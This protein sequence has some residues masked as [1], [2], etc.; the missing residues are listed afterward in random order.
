M[1]VEKLLTADT[2]A[3]LKAVACV[4]N[5]G[6]NDFAVA[7]AGMLAKA[8]IPLQNDDAPVAKSWVVGN[9]IGN[10]E[11]NHAGTHYTYIKLIQV[12]DS[13]LPTCDPAFL[14]SRPVPRCYLSEG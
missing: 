7:T 9:L 10:S 8:G 13:L 12:D 6:M 2:E 5:A 4:V 1:L 3:G 11:S 14:P